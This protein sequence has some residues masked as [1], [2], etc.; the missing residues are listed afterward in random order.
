MTKQNKIFRTIFRATAILTLTSMMNMKYINASNIVNNNIGNINPTSQKKEKSPD[1][2]KNMIESQNLPKEDLEFLDLRDTDEIKDNTVDFYNAF[3]AAFNCY[4]YSV[5]GGTSENEIAILREMCND[6]LKKAYKILDNKEK[7]IDFNALI[8]ENEETDDEERFTITAK[9]FNAF[10]FPTNCMYFFLDTTIL[11]K[12][13]DHK[14]SITS[15]TI[16]NITFELHMTAYHYVDLEENIELLEKERKSLEKN[17][18]SLEASK[19]LLDANTKYLNKI[20]GYLKEIFLKSSSLEVPRTLY[21][22]E[23]VKVINEVF[24]SIID[25]PSN[26]TIDDAFQLYFQCNP[27]IYFPDKPHQNGASTSSVTDKPDNTHVNRAS[28]SLTSELIN[29]IVEKI[30]KF[31]TDIISYINNND[32]TGLQNFLLLHQE[33]LD[34]FYTRHKVEFEKYLNLRFINEISYTAYDIKPADL[35]KNSENRNSTLA[36]VIGYILDKNET[37]IKDK[38]LQ[39]N[40]KIWEENDFITEPIKRN[41]DSVNKNYDENYDE[42]YDE[43]S[44]KKNKPNN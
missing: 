42:S 10:L 27:Y 24:K 16:E 38:Y 7:R 22:K 41:R 6:Y 15:D 19:K 13:L 44:H 31:V 39:G 8:I 43:P 4:H 36:K 18:K 20:S 40:D 5:N 23:D 9:I 37:I 2:L 12:L 25:Q 28:P 17:K 30:I 32:I 11:D 29:I 35:L 14:I 33:N 34:L 1:E 3:T 21:I 26:Q